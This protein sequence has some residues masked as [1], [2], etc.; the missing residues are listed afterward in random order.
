MSVRT[1]LREGLVPDGIE[2]VDHAIKELRVGRGEGEETVRR[3]VPAAYD[4]LANSDEELTQE[5]IAERLA[6]V[7][8]FPDADDPREWG[9]VVGWYLGVLPGV[10][11]ETEVNADEG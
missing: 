9:D 5:E 10:W 11:K 6:P 3:A 2:D 4:Q 7:Y 1:E 8:P